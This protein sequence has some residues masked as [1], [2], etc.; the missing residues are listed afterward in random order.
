MRFSRSLRCISLILAASIGC[1]VA[2][3]T[4]PR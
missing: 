4:T 2:D 3:G 1:V